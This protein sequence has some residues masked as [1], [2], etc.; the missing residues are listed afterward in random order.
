MRS[1]EMK[2]CSLYI[3]DFR[4]PSPVS[5]QPSSMTPEVIKKQMILE[6]SAH[7]TSIWGWQATLCS[8]CQPSCLQLG[9][10]SPMWWR[11]SIFR[12]MTHLSL[13]PKERKQ[14]EE[15]PVSHPAAPSSPLH[16]I[17]FVECLPDPVGTTPTHPLLSIL[18]G[19]PVYKPTPPLIRQRQD[20]FWRRFRTSCWTF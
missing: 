10:V 3:A 7:L 17:L 15:A 1:K 9:P 13:W 20:G 5:Q 11:V 6:L 4:Q 14:N 2:V 12:I 18:W 19:F 16:L 8:D